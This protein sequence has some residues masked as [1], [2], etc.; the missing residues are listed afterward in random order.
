MGYELI[1]RLFAE[2]PNFHRS[3]DEPVTWNSQRAVL[4]FIA[5]TMKPGMASL[6]TGCGYST[7][8]FAASGADHVTVTPEADEERR[9]RE[10]CAANAIDASA[11]AFAIGP[12]HA[13]LPQLI[14]EGPLDLVY[15]DGAHGFPHP[16]VD[17]MFTETRLKVGGWMLVDDIRIPTCRMVHN[18]LAADDAWRLERLIGDTSVFVRVAE[19]K[20]SAMW[21]PQG[22]NR[23]YP[24]F[25]FLPL[26]QRLRLAPRARVNAEKVLRRVG[27]YEAAR[28]V[29][30]RT[31]A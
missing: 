24:D 18:F 28:R 5:D 13:V 30:D 31:A 3:G 26:H 7:V 6:E 19:G 14:E 29:L 23:K 9:V 2:R 20:N 16:S 10:W 12:S 27:L 8:M 21:M 4:S 1:D 11:L 15:I 17:W 25:S 22:Y